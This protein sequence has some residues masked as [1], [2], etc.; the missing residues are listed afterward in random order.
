VTG[1]PRRTI[2]H[3][4][5]ALA[6]TALLWLASL[7]LGRAT[8]S[9]PTPHASPLPDPEACAAT[10]AQLLAA[11]GLPAEVAFTPQATLHVTIPHPTTEGASP[12][13]AAQA[14]WPAFDAAAQLP[15]SCPFR[16]LVVTVQT[17]D[18]V[19]Q[20]EVAAGDLLAWSAGSLDDN[21]LIERVAYTREP[22]PP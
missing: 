9:T 7:L 13:E 1:P 20:A 21:A 6:A 15:P 12:D 11:T 17:D 16:H 3:L 4:L 18:L 19:L 10:L 2:R 5:L 22:H 14:I 8:P